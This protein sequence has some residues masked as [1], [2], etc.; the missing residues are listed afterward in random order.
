MSHIEGTD[1]VV[2]IPFVIVKWAGLIEKGEEPKGLIVL[3]YYQ[4]PLMLTKGI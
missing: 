4:I 3:I 2:I 1:L